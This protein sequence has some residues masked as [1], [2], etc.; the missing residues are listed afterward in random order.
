MDVLNLEI[1]PVVQA[2]QEVLR[3][4]TI[5]DELGVRAVNGNLVRDDSLGAGDKGPEFRLVSQPACMAVVERHV[6]AGDFEFV[7]KPSC[8]QPARE[9]C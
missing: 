5:F 1:N 8:P 3:A 2:I 7:G 9:V 4:I 6:R